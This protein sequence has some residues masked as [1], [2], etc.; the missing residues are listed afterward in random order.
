[1][2][3]VACAWQMRLMTDADPLL[4]A[5]V[6][7]ALQLP[8]VLLVIPAGVLTDLADRRRVMIWTHVWLG[9]G[10]GALFWLTVTERITP[11]LLLVVLPLI[12]VGQALR[13]PGIATLIPDLVSTRQIPAAVSLN[14]MAQ[15]SS[16]II[17]P[18]LAGALI[19]STGVAAVLAVNASVMILIIFLFLRLNYRPEK[20]DLPVSAQRFFDAITEGLRFAAAT[21]WQRNILIRLGTFFACSASIPALMAVRFDDSETYGFMYACFG[22]GSLIGLLVIGKL[23]HQ[24]LDRRLTGALFACALFMMFFGLV[25]RPALAALLLAGIGAG[26]I[27]CSNSIMVAAQM[28]LNSSMRGRGLSFVFAVG[29]ACLAGG[30]LLWGAVAQITSPTAALVASGLCLLGLLAATHR[31]SICAPNDQTIPLA[32]N[33]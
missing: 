9:F 29:T 25:D 18:A 14:S 22:G 10:L 19:A 21:R 12:A 2:T 15:T 20:N 32:E 26:W 31:L 17:G 33:T 23:G 6:Y 5:S 7:T 28:Q 1:M 4:V 16:R 3:E 8:I 13:M 24:K 27:F 30:G 11:L